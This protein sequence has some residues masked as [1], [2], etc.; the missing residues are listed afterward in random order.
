MKL[1]I[2]IST[3]AKLDIKDIFDWY[4]TQSTGLGSKFEKEFIIAIDELTH[5]PQKFQIRYQNV[6]IHFLKKFPYGIHFQINENSILIIAVF[7]TSRKPKKQ[8]HTNTKSNDRNASSIGSEGSN[9]V[10][11]V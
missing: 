3:A 4:E 8:P 7:H 2:L 9:S 5:Q 10:T 11:K 1:N 6:R